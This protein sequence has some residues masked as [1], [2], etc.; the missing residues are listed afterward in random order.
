MSQNHH[1]HHAHPNPQFPPEPGSGSK[2]P[3]PTPSHSPSQVQGSDTYLARAQRNVVPAPLNSNGRPDYTGWRPHHT[4]IWQDKELGPYAS[5]RPPLSNPIS[6]ATM[7]TGLPRNTNMS[8]FNSACWGT[9][10]PTL[11]QAQ[12]TDESGTKTVSIVYNPFIPNGPTKDELRQRII[13][14]PIV[15][16]GQQFIA[17]LPTP[18]HVQI[19]KVYVRNMDLSWTMTREAYIR[20]GLMEVFSK[21]GKVV[22]ITLPIW[23]NSKN[24]HERYHLDAHVFLSLDQDVE[25]LRSGAEQ[26][27]PVPG[28][29]N[30][31]VYTSWENDPPCALCKNH[32]HR[33]QRC[34]KL[35]NATCYNCQQT[36]HYAK[37]CR[38]QTVDKVITAQSTTVTS[39]PIISTT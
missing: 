36:G 20:E 22:K 15:Y 8:D 38:N 7:Y 25:T 24:V 26:G 4:T 31:R 10:G 12:D 16:Q 33:A 27:Y 9:I 18:D 30:H 39:A 6:C 29:A 37:R 32:G 3:S 5:H 13:N 21:F 23:R 19:T 28:W 1:S 11:G 35:K 17:Q 2:S 34:P 14:T